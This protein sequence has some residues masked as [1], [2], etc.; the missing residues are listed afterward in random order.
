MGDVEPVFGNL[1]NNYFG[2]ETSSH[3]RSDGLR[4]LRTMQQVR[5]RAVQTMRSYRRSRY[6]VQCRTVQWV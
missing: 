4:F 6:R 2:P 3:V 1:Q 5:W